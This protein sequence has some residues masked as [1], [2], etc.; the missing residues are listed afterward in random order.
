[1]NGGCNFVH[2][3]HDTLK[4]RF[5]ELCD[6][7]RTEST[8]DLIAASGEFI[9]CHRFGRQREVPHNHMQVDAGI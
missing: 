7:G 5:I 9:L 2:A 1:M 4:R 8:K 6:I 3:L